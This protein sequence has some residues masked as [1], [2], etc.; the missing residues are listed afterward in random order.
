M[1][2][3]RTRPGTSEQEDTNKNPGP[4]LPDPG[5]VGSGPDGPTP[6]PEKPEDHDSEIDTGDVDL[7]PM[8]KET[9][10]PDKAFTTP[11]AE[12]TCDFISVNGQG[13]V[14]VWPDLDWR[15]YYR[16]DLRHS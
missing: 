11:G 1:Q 15:E 8:A 12:K 9:E 16:S 3:L 7:E 5:P 13:K 10:E 6:N 14:E 2:P 4:L